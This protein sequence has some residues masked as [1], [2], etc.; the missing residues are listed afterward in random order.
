V[1]YDPVRY[2]NERAAAKGPSY[3]GP[4]SH[5][6]LAYREGLLFAAWLAE[7]I[8]EPVDFLLD[9]GCGSAR[10]TPTLV[11]LCATYFGVDIAK[12]GLEAAM[13]EWGEE[14]PSVRFAR[15]AP[16]L[17]P[18]ESGMMDAAVAAT[19]LQH[20]PDDDIGLVLEEL[21][22]VVRGD[23][24]IYV[25]DANPDVV[26]EP[27]EHMFPRSIERIAAALD[28]NVL[29]SEELGGHVFAVLGR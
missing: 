8:A 20:V 22:R 29:E 1:S 3:V 11:E 19:V 10:L 9:F 16:P 21:A 2:W 5:P 25:I 28:R 26:I 17:L 6:R 7:K 15:I 27:H 18:Y 13:R 23:G 24:R 14:N 4:G 12:P